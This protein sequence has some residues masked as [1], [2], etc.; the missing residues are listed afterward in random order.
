MKEYHILI[1]DIQKG[2]FSIDELKKIEL[3]KSSLVWCKELD[4]WT[5]LQNVS[6]LKE[7]LESTP[8]PIPKRIDKK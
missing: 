6:E 8:P 1:N 7:L 2:P 3:N 5:E 4:N